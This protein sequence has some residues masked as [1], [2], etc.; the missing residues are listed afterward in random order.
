MTSLH[1]RNR[2]YSEEFEP[3]RRW[4]RARVIAILVLMAACSHYLAFLGG[5]YM[6]SKECKTAQQLA[7]MT[8]P[9]CAATVS[10]GLTQWNCSENEF[11]EHASTC[12]QRG[13]HVPAWFKYIK[14]KSLPK[15]QQP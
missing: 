1:S 8:R 15:E 11:K 5:A 3:P 13:K 4:Q 10:N 12:A 6:K 7:M 14:P 2:H 9:T